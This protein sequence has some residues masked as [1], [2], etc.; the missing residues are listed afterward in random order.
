MLVATWIITCLLIVLAGIYAGRNI[1]TKAQWTGGDHSLNEMDIAFILV[2]WQIGGMAIVGAAQSGYTTGMSIS[3]QYVFHASYFLF[4]AIFAKVLRERIKVESMATFL[5][6]RFGTLNRRWYIVIWS[7]YAFICYVPQQLKTMVSI[8]NIAF[9]GINYIL[10]MAIGLALPLAYTFFSGI[11]GSASVGR[12]VSIGMY[13][14]IIGFILATLPKFGGYSGLIAQSS[15]ATA[16]NFD[17][18][19][20]SR[21]LSW[22]IGTIIGTSV[23]QSVLQPIMAAKSPQAARRGSLAAYFL[24]IPI[25]G[26]TGMIGVMASASNVDLGDGSTAFAWAIRNYS[27]PAVA[28]IIFAL[29]TMIISATMQTILLATGTILS[30]LYTTDIRKEASEDEALRFTR[31]ATLVGAVVSMIMTVVLPNDSL[32]Y[33]GSALT[34]SA[35]TPISFSVFGSLF[36]KRTSKWG[37]FWSMVCGFA[38][39]I[40]WLIFGLDSKVGPVLYPVFIVTYTVGIVVSLLTTN[41]DGTLKKVEKAC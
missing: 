10:A 4:I 38:T 16:G 17:Q 6:D 23:S 25:T 18:I 13:A 2:A 12:I 22:A 28:G 41:P 21:L 40:L 39:G 35:T 8:V 14:F 37:S 34:Q 15:V 32:T 27:H 31:I 36:W 20:L 5:G 30:D 3:L 1:K 33:L 9:P 19:P 7:A 29:A 11:R 24:V 26:L